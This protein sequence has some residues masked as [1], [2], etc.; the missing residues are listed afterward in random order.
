MSRVNAWGRKEKFTADIMLVIKLDDR[1]PSNL[2][3]KR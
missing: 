3:P 2:V 1:F